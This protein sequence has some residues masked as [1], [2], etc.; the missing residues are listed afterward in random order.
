MPANRIPRIA[1]KRSSSFRRLHWAIAAWY[2]RALHK[3]LTRQRAKIEK[4]LAVAAAEAQANALL[5]RFARAAAAPPVA[6]R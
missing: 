3:S 2:L 1:P 5:Y 4:K 6:A